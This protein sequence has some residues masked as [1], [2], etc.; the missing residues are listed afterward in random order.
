[1]TKT[2]CILL[3]DGFEEAEALVPADYLARLG[4]KVKFVGTTNTKVRGTHNFYI[5][6]DTT[7]DNISASDFDALIL[8]G[9]LPGT[10][11]LRND[12]RVLNLVRQTFAN[13]KL[14]AA[15]CAAP[16]ILRDAQITDGL[17]LTGYPECERLSYNPDF[18]FSGKPIEIQNNVIT[19][20][21]MGQAANF[22]FAI[23]HALGT[24]QT[25]LQ[26]LAASTF[27]VI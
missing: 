1:M 24:K 11:N 19:A 2:I 16:I 26:Q 20:I 23:A 22:A 13:N 3:A 6:S 18:K 9:G 25:E 27:T 21:G 7:L 8:P 12:E 10:I 4:Y 17:T 5:H 14:C 15:I